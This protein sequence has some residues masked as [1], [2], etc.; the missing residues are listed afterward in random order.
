MHKAAKGRDLQTGGDKVLPGEAAGPFLKSLV[1]VSLRG[2]P[3]V[4]PGEARLG[5]VALLAEDSGSPPACTSRVPEAA[6][7]R[8]SR[9]FQIEG[10]IVFLATFFTETKSKDGI[11]D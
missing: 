10:G 2:G 8:S 6:R 9:E 7:V 1:W 5:T 4:S 11:C 3:A